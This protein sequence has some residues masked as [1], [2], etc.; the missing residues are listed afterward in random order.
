MSFEHPEFVIDLS[1]AGTLTVANAPGG[2]VAP[3]PCEVTHV[4]A[5]V[6]TAP[7]TGPV[8][9]D[10]LKN[11][12]SV[13]TGVNSTKPTIAAGSTTSAVVQGARAIPASTTVLGAA[14]AQ[15]SPGTN[16][17]RPIVP[18]GG[19]LI[20]L[21]AGDR[22]SVGVTTIGTTPAGSDLFVTVGVMKK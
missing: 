20:S 4:V 21:A 3:Y 22:L 19:A 11:G 5:R 12:A 10:L 13:F 1:V 14:G 15:Y 9:V 17:I 8:T 7:G 18:D 2:W 16:D 6:G